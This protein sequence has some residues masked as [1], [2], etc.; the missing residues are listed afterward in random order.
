MK[1]ELVAGSVVALWLVGPPRRVAVCCTCCISLGWHC[2]AAY[3]IVHLLHWDG[4]LVTV[5]PFSLPSF[6]YLI[7]TVHTLSLALLLLVASL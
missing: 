4:I 6:P 3:T 5:E 7:S 1:S 2:A